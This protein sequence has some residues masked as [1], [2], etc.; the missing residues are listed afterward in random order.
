MSR[1]VSRNAGGE[2]GQKKCGSRFA[3][4]LPQNML[5]II[6]PV[7]DALIVPSSTAKSRLYFSPPKRARERGNFPRPVLPLAMAD[8]YQQLYEPEYC[9]TIRQS[10]VYYLVHILPLSRRGHCTAGAGNCQGIFARGR[11]IKT[12][13]EAA[14]SLAPGY[15]HRVHPHPVI[16]FCHSYLCGGVNNWPD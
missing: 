6:Y 13:P 8:Y 3:L 10:G 16:S 2:S 9:L 11:L 5:K 7:R 4:L 1:T 15:V 14:S 12:H